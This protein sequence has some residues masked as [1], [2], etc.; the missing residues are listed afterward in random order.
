MHVKML[1]ILPLLLELYGC[2]TVNIDSVKEPGFKE[3]LSRTLI[4][5]S[6]NSLMFRITRLNGQEVGANLSNRLSARGVTVQTVEIHDLVKSEQEN[7]LTQAIA[8]FQPIQV[9]KLVPLKA[10]SLLGNPTG[11]ELECSI[12]HGKNMNPVWRAS[13]HYSIQVGSGL[14]ADKLVIALVQKLDDDGL[15]PTR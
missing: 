11:Y 1:L 3:T 6:L 15:L 10:D 12:Y 7:E 5:N 9:L 8:D 13:I 14:D 4:A 2:A